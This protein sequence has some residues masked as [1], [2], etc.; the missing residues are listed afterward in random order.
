VIKY[1]DVEICEAKTSELVSAC[2]L[3]LKH[4]ISRIDTYDLAAFDLEAL[5]ELSFVALA[6]TE[7]FRLPC[8]S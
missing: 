5:A 1:H 4:T 6:E 7:R 3:Q 2:L 8:N